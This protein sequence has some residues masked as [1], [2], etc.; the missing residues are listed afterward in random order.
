MVQYTEAH[1]YNQLTQFYRLLD[2]QRVIEK[3]KY[4]LEWFSTFASFLEC[5]LTNVEMQIADVGERMAAEHKLASVR[6]AL[7]LAL[8][9]INRIRDRNAYRFVKLRELC[10]TVADPW[11]TK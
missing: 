8:E 2:A 3:V 4:S 7:D 5:E 11:T 10:V 9:I 6:P 1:L